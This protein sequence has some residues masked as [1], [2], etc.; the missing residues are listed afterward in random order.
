MIPVH[1]STQGRLALW[2]T[3]VGT[4]RVVAAHN[5]A[6]RLW[7]HGLRKIT[8]EKAEEITHAWQKTLEITDKAEQ[9]VVQRGVACDAV[10][11]LQLVSKTF[12]VDAYRE[13]F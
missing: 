6:P 8:K 4:Y 13:V 7:S 12:M 11:S 2:E 3:D 1:E 5:G 10:D 9:T